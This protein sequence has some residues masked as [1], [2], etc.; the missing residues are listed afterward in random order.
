M[1]SL[2]RSSRTLGV[3][4]ALM[5]I[6]AVAVVAE[7]RTAGAEGNGRVEGS[8]LISGHSDT[9]NHTFQVVA[10][11]DPGGAT[12]LVATDLANSTLLGQWM[13]T[14]SDGVIATY[15]G[16]AFDA[17]RHVVGTVKIHSTLEVTSGSL[18]GT[19]QATG[20]TPSGGQLFPP[21]HGPIKGSRIKAG[22]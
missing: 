4:L 17:A 6:L 1:H 8:Y 21:Q 20:I 18:T 14:E 22:S 11:F 7:M 9:D 16:Y 2:Y 19:F 15:Y 13:L 10:A 3:A 12:S 5:T